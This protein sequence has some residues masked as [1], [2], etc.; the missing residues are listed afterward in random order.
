MVFQI[1]RLLAHVEDRRTGLRSRIL[2][3]LTA[4]REMLPFLLARDSASFADPISLGDSGAG[5]N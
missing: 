5:R 1:G 2:P 4:V 3:P